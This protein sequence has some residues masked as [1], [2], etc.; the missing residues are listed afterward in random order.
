MKKM[1]VLSFA[2]VMLFASTALAA[3]LTLNGIT[4]TE[5]TGDFTITGALGAGSSSDPFI[6]NETVTGLDVTMSIEGLAAYG[7]PGDPLSEESIGFHNSGFYLTKIVTN[8][9]GATWNFYDHELQEILGTASTDGDGLSFAQGT[10]SVRP[11]T[12]DQFSLVDEVTDV[13]DYVNFYGGTVLEGQTVTMNLVI[14]D[15][16]DNN[17][18]IFYLRQRPN[19]QPGQT[20]PEPSTLLL[21]GGGLIG[22]AGFRRKFKV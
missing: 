19:F 17:P 4:F 6:L 14:T 20:V 21:L 9:T 5:T 15:N 1:V 13:R 8:N 2:V 3:P 16:S 18:D 10:T 7:L 12:S 22:L 11:F